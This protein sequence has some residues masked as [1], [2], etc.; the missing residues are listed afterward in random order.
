MENL[1]ITE[2]LQIFLQ[3]LVSNVDNYFETKTDRIHRKQ[4]LKQL[5]FDHL[6][7]TLKNGLDLHPVFKKGAKKIEEGLLISRKN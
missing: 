7:P 3:N 4:T 2:E 1:N 5:V 6:K